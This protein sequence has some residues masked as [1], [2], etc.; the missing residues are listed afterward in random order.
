M[1]QVYT[2]QAMLGPWHMCTSC[3]ST[4]PVASTCS[5]KHYSR[6]G[7]PT[8]VTGQSSEAN[9]KL[10]VCAS[11][12]RLQTSHSGKLKFVVSFWINSAIQSSLEL[13][14]WWSTNPSTRQSRGTTRDIWEMPHAFPRD[15]FARRILLQNPLKMWATGCA[16]SV[17][18][19]KP[20]TWNVMKKRRVPT[21]PSCWSC[22]RRR[23]ELSGHRLTWP[24]D[25]GAVCEEQ[26]G[27]QRFLASLPRHCTRWRTKGLD[28]T[29]SW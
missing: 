7:H 14:D 27:R 22:R 24:K 29:C 11:W 28:A 5:T 8:A 15:I 10:C 20:S 3:Q 18:Y 25:E 9:C 2:G 19:P 12:S 1:L 16:A 17:L 21:L 4:D 6:Q 23:R 26:S 13:P